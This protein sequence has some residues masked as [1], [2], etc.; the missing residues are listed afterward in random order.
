MVTPP[1]RWKEQFV[2]SPAV[3]KS[4]KTLEKRLSGGLK[5]AQ[6]AQTELRIGG[7]APMNGTLAAV[8]M[9]RAQ[10]N[11]PPRVPLETNCHYL[12]QAT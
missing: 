12:G 11:L 9:E 4:S 7:Q 2:S 1:A 6:N 10:N 3:Q 8:G 5:R